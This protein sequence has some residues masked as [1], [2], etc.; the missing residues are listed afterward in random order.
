MAREGGPSTIIAKTDA[1][2]LQ[3]RAAALCTGAAIIC[4]LAHPAKFQKA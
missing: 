4:W 2:V 1:H 3:Q